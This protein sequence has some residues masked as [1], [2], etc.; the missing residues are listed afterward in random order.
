MNTDTEPGIRKFY[1][2]L[3]GNLNI[4]PQFR[5]K[6]FNVINILAHF[7]CT[8]TIWNHHLHSAVSFVYSVDPDFTGLKILG[9]NAVQNNIQNYVE[10]CCVAMSKGWHQKDLMERKDEAYVWD[11]VLEQQGKPEEAAKNRTTFK[12][13]F[14]VKMG[15]MVRTI[16]NRNLHRIA[17]YSA[18]SPQHLQS[19]ARL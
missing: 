10:Y 11:K 7:I 15:T 3:L 19:S 2:S 17:P 14:E 8:A 16:H 4:D 12:D 9:N 13:F 18:L 1:N 6:K 5:L